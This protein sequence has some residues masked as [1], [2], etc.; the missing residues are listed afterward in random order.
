MVKICNRRK[1]NPV[2][3]AVIFF[4]GAVGVALSLPDYDLWFLAWFALIPLID[5]VRYRRPEQPFLCSWL[6]SM[7]V[8]SVSFSWVMN[9]MV[10]YG[11][12]SWML[13]AGV[14][15]LLALFQG[16]YTALAVWMAV[17]L[18]KR[19]P[20]KVPAA[21][22]LAACWVSLDYIRAHMP[23]GFSFPWNSL[24]QSQH[25]FS[26][27]LQNADW[28]SYFGLTFLIVL[29]NGS[30]VALIRREK[31][32]GIQFIVAIILVVSACLYGMIPDSSVADQRPF[33]V[34][35]VQGNLD[36]NEK[37]QPENRIRFLTRQQ[38]LSRQLMGD[39]PDMFL[40]S[41]SAL[42][43]IYRYAWRYQDPGGSPGRLMAE[44][45]EETRIPLLTG[46]LDKTGDDTYNAAVLTGIN[47]PEVYYY[48][49]RL[50]PF[51]EFVPLENLFFFVQRMVE[52]GIG[53]FARGNSDEPV[54]H[55]LGTK[56]A[57]T[58]CYENIFPD[59]I[60]KRVL[61]GGEVII[62]ITNDAWFGESSASA[63]LL[64]ASRFRAVE[65]HR[66]VIRCANTG[67][68]GAIDAR[69]QLLYETALFTE[70]A[71][72]VTVFPSSMK[73]L[74]TVYG[75]WFAFGCILSTILLYI[76]TLVLSILRR[77]NEN[78]R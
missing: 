64:A 51:G 29:F 63:Q 70:D 55:P 45:M 50:V 4:A 2:L 27:L 34:G 71:F 53:T 46:T 16:V 75:D 41:E 1:R 59:L 52:E 37:W 18:H 33:S 47:Q 15:V 28:G 7:I 56:M 78:V 49:E 10:N 73:T 6:F 67:I 9:S 48:K 68:S 62:N 19:L 23:L 74:Y 17:A 22:I 3:N 43:F 66:P 31:T 54:V 60:R 65:T 21:P 5:T 72:N 25:S 8:Y 35:V 26:P 61:A 24:G 69:G 36:L 58:I 39:A 11:G 44:F 42:P 40:W 12:M 76:W 57:I 20:E 38:N 32:G 14:L 30:L 77:S 13:A